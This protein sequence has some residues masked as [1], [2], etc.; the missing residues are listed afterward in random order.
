MG[1][2]PPGSIYYLGLGGE[3]DKLCVHSTPEG[4][5]EV[6]C[7]KSNVCCLKH[8]EATDHHLNIREHCGDAF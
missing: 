6:W 2:G 3:E 8:N 4:P 1:R 5:G 7:W